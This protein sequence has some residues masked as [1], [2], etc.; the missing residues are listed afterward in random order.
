MMKQTFDNSDVTRWVTAYEAALSR[1]FSRVQAGL[2][3]EGREL[4][5]VSR[6]HQYLALAAIAQ[7][8]LNRALGHFAAAASAWAVVL[9][10]FASDGQ[11]DRGIAER[12][13]QGFILA[14]GSGDERAMQR[15]VRSFGE[16]VKEAPIS[17]ET[18][19]SIGMAL[20]ELVR[21]DREA[22]H[23]WSTSVAKHDIRTAELLDAIIETDES[24]LRYAV[25]AAVEDWK[26]RI[27][28]ER[29]QRFPD[30]VCD[31]RMIGWLRL[32]EHVWGLRPDVDLS[33]ARVPPEIFDAFAEPVQSSL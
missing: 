7:L 3:D 24:H 23:Q 28:A 10:R 27:R 12:A 33:E 8:Q 14:A 17:G 21:C 13:W 6:R 31:D 5:D 15:M 29:L 11:I 9:E 19:V 22:A 2:L 26:K 1:S 16:A 32:A 30:A 25:K 20:L 18:T 4:A